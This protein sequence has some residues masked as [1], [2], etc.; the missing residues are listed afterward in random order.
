MTDNRIVNCCRYNVLTVNESLIPPVFKGEILPDYSEGCII[1]FEKKSCLCIKTKNEWRM[2]KMR[3]IPSAPMEDE[4]E[5]YNIN[6]HNNTLTIDFDNI[7]EEKLLTKIQNSLKENKSDTKKI[8]LKGAKNKLSKDF[9]SIL[10]RLVKNIKY[11]K[12]SITLGL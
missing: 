4:N 9:E 7:S 1:Y 6:I 11:E 10:S 12:D 5:K 2:L 3:L 8:K